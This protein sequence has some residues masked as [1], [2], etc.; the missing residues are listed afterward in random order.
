MSTEHVDDIKTIREI[1]NVFKV[2]AQ[3]LED[4]RVQL[5]T[6]IATTGDNSWPMPVNPK[7][8]IWNAQKTFKVDL[9]QTSDMHPL[10]IVGAVDKLQE[11]LPAVHG[12]DLLSI[13]AQKNATLLF[14]IHLRSKRSLVAPGEMIGCVATQSLGEPATQMTL[15]TFHY[16]GVS[17]K[18]PDINKI[19]D[20]AKNVQCALEY[21]TL[22]SVTQ[23]T[24]VWYD[25]EPKCTFGLFNY[26][27][28]VA[29]C[30]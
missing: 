12:D 13:E 14:N 20:Q 5:G 24:A 1:H 2:E 23:A 17:A 27:S 16:A 11:R 26:R 25:P 3:Q 22:S 8:I 28:C 30:V 15:N 7:R 9:R 18:N 10:E 19:K 4:D 21:T 29:V 6:E